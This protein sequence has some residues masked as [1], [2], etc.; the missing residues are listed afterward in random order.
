MLSSIV[1][2]IINVNIKKSLSQ[3]CSSE[4]TT[5]IWQRMLQPQLKYS[6]QTINKVHAYTNCIHIKLT[7]VFNC[8]STMYMHTHYNKWANLLY[9]NWGLASIHR[10]D[11][12]ASTQHADWAQHYYT[13]YSHW[14]D[15]YRNAMLPK[16]N[17]WNSLRTL[18]VEEAWRCQAL[19][20]LPLSKESA[21]QIIQC[22][23]FWSCIKR[24]HDGHHF[25]LSIVWL[26]MV[27][28]I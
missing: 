6:T 16:I 21:L 2:V 18:L 7:A 11:L 5:R 12:P 14:Y 10:T 1:T 26:I 24:K 23:K 22:Q 20:T 3:V 8:K 4:I 9:C 13:A 17:S 19:H 28:A 15:S 25:T 27:I